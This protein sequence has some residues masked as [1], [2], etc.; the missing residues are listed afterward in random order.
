MCRQLLENLH[1]HRQNNFI[2]QML[3]HHSL[4]SAKYMSLWIEAKNKNARQT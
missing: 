3:N 1:I 4:Q 2:G